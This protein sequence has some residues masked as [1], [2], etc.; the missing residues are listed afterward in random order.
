MFI[1]LQR[2]QSSSLSRNIDS[3]GGA[4][5]D[6]A[7]WIGRPDATRGQDPVASLRP[8]NHILKIEGTTLY[9]INLEIECSNDPL[10]R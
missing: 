4:A 8:I 1:R 7:P 6:A 2:C 9:D 10:D 3:A 5:T